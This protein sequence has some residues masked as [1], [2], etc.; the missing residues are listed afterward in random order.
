MDVYFH[1]ASMCVPLFSL[2][3]RTLLCS[4]VAL[5]HSNFAAIW[6]R[7][8]MFLVEDV[9]MANILNA[10][11][12]IVSAGDYTGVI[13]E[14]WS[15]TRQSIFIGEV[16]N[17][18]NPFALVYGDDSWFNNTKPYGLNCEPF[19]IYNHCMKR[20]SGWTV[21]QNE[22]FSG[23]QRFYNIYDGPTGQERN[24]YM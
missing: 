5:V 23:F 18:H 20:D 7:D 13:P 3:K 15:L 8:G 16:P 24:A 2:T 12:T 14:Y 10:G 17:N 6:L 4:L 1:G 9:R 21:V 11:I 22:G 19:R